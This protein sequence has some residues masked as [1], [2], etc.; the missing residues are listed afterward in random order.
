MYK[1]VAYP[2]KMLYLCTEFRINVKNDVGFVIV[3]TNYL[4]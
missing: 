2:K 3:L 4:R 1:I